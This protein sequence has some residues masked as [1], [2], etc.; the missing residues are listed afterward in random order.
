MAEQEEDDWEEREIIDR[1]R[2]LGFQFQQSMQSFSTALMY[3]KDCHVM[4]ESR[5][6]PVHEIDAAMACLLNEK[7]LYYSRSLPEG[8]FLRMRRVF[9]DLY[10]THAYFVD[11]LYDQGLY[12]CYTR[13]ELSD[14]L[15]DEF[16]G[17]IFQADV[18]Y[19]E[20]NL[21]HDRFS[22]DHDQYYGQQNLPQERHPICFRNEFYVADV[23]DVYQKKDKGHCFYLLDGLLSLKNLGTGAYQPE[24]SHWLADWN[25]P[26]PRC[27]YG[28][29]VRFKI[30]KIDAPRN[31]GHV[32]HARNISCEVIERFPKYRD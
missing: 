22:L 31:W 32:D 21:D 9:F 10:A 17:Q 26:E 16:C 24:E 13:R 28:D 30:Q 2:T 11:Y 25:H 19:L 27:T 7:V 3:C 6:G 15:E 14:L 18:R 12:P 5:E 23:R 20:E 1:A 4:L 29:T 8:H